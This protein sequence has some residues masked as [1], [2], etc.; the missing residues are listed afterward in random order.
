MGHNDRQQRIALHER[1]KVVA[2]RANRVLS[3]ITR[4][5]KPEDIDD[6]PEWAKGK[7][8]G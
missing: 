4:S 6:L 1:S 7:K 2:E 5:T 3:S 8:A